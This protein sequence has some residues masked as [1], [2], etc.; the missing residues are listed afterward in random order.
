M[1]YVTAF[2]RFWYDFIVGDSV[3]LAI[4]AP[5]ILALAY[6]FAHTGGAEAAQ[7]LLP[8]AV[9]A[10]LAASLALRSAR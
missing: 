2:V 3:V 10:T 4:G 5:V 7:V 1:R 6:L 8:V 9:V